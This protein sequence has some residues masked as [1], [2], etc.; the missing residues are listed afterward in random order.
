MMGLP[1]FKGVQ[2]RNAALDKLVEDAKRFHTEADAAQCANPWWASMEQEASKEEEAAINATLAKE[3]VSETVRAALAAVAA[4]PTASTDK[5]EMMRADEAPSG[6]GHTGSDKEEGFEVAL[7]TAPTDKHEMMRADEAPSG[8]GH[9]GSDKEEGFEV[10]LPT[11][12]T[13]KHEMMRADEAPSGV[14]PAGSD[15]EEG[16]E[17][18]LPRPNGGCSG[19][20]CTQPELRYRPLHPA[21][22]GSH[23]HREWLVESFAAALEDGSEAALRSILRQEVENRVVSFDMLRPEFCKQLLDELQHYEASGLPI[24]RPNTM[25]RVHLI[26]AHRGV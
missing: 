7:P 12:P 1:G 13:D 9:T 22:F 8:V 4:Q 3:V 23:F 14:G 20:A 19:G 24:H 5:H 11:A 25:V 2:S 18:A 16:F 15:K 10:A 6:V 21:L 17:V 26:R